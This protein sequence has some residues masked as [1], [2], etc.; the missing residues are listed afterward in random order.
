MYPK[1]FFYQ[2]KSSQAVFSSNPPGEIDIPLFIKGK[3]C[4]KRGQP[5]CEPRKKTLI[6]ADWTAIAWP[7][8]KQIEFRNGLLKLLDDDFSLY[9]WQDGEVV[10][11]TARFIARVDFDTNGNIHPFFAKKVTPA[12]ADKILSIASKQLHFPKDQLH[13]L[14]DYWM[15]TLIDFNLQGQAR[16]IDTGLYYQR[17]TDRLYDNNYADDRND[18]IEVLYQAVPPV[19]VIVSSILPDPTGLGETFTEAFPEAKVEE[20]YKVLIL[21][22]RHLLDDIFEIQTSSNPV[23]DIAFDFTAV[24]SIS[25]INGDI[26]Y[27]DLALIARTFDNL[28]HVSLSLD[29]YHCNEFP[30]DFSALIQLEALSIYGRDIVNGTL[31]A[32][33]SATLELKSLEITFSITQSPL[34]FEIFPLLKLEHLSIQNGFFLTPG[35][36][37]SLLINSPLLKTFRITNCEYL[38]FQ[39]D[40]VLEQLQILQVKLCALNMSNFFDFLKDKS[41]LTALEINNCNLSQNNSLGLISPVLSRLETINIQF[42]DMHGDALD[43]LIGSSPALKNLV[44]AN[45]EMPFSSNCHF[46]SRKLETLAITDC[47]AINI[48]C[49]MALPFIVNLKKLDLTD[50]TLIFDVYPQRVLPL[51]VLKLGAAN[52]SNEQLKQ[53]LRLLP[54]LKQLDLNQCYSLDIECDS[55]LRELLGKIAQVDWSDD[56]HSFDESASDLSDSEDEQVECLHDPRNFIDN[57]P[58]PDE[59]SFKFQGKNKTFNQRMIIE[60]L[61]QYLKIKNKHLALIP[62]LQG[63]ICNALSMRF[64]QLSLEKW[65]AFIKEIDFWDG[66]RY[67]LTVTMEAIFEDLLYTVQ[68]FQLK[69][70]EPEYFLG[71]SA[72]DFLKYHRATLGSG[73]VLSNPWHA[74]AVKYISESDEW[75][76]YDPNFLEGFEFFSEDVLMT[77]LHRSLGALILVC[78]WK[79]QLPALKPL[80]ASHF[81]SEGGLLALTK[82]QNHAEILVSFPEMNAL[83]NYKWNNEAFDG[84]FLRTSRG[85]PAWVLGLH[86]SQIQAYTLSVL[87]QCILENP[88][89][90]FQRIAHSME[91]LTPV[92]KQKILSGL[93][94]ETKPDALIVNTVTQAISQA[95]NKIYYLN[96]LA[97]WHKHKA[98]PETLPAYCQ[99]LIS[100]GNRN[101]K[102]LIELNGPTSV[103]ALQLALQSHCIHNA[104]PVFY[105]DHP[106]DLVC[107]A[108]Y[109]KLIKHH[110]GQLKK[111]PGGHLHDFL[112]MAKGKTDPAPVLIINYA[113]FKADDIVRMNSLLDD[114][115]SA[116]GTPIPEA[117]QLI[118]LYDHEAVD[119]Y[120]GEDFYSRFDL[121]ERCPL[122]Q[123]ALDVSISPLPLREFNAEMNDNEFP[124]LISLYHDSNWKVRLLGHWTLKNNQLVFEEGVLVK[125]LK[126][127]KPGQDILIENGL[128]D[129]LSFQQFWH[130]AFLKGYIECEG[131]TIHWPHDQQLVCKEGYQWP[132]L[133]G[134]LIFYLGLKPDVEVLNPYTL[135]AYFSRY[136]CDNEQETLNSLPGWIET[137][138][139][140]TLHVNLT[141]DLSQDEWAMLLD[142][143]RHWQVRLDCHVYPGY[144]APGFLQANWSDAAEEIIQEDAAAPAAVLLISSDPDITQRKLIQLNKVWKII[145]ISECS[146]SD[147]LGGIEGEVDSDNARFSFRQTASSLQTLLQAEE[148][149]ILKGHFST[150]LMDALAPLLLARLAYPERCM[151]QLYLVTQD[152]EAFAYLGCNEDTMSLDDKAGCLINDGFSEAEI[153]ALDV[154]FFEREPLSRCKA[155]L[156]HLRRH[157]DEPIEKSWQ[158]LM[159]PLDS[160]PPLQAINLEQSPQIT[161]AFTKRRLQ[162]LNQALLDGPYVFLSGLTGVGKS[163]F[164]EKEM[165]AQSNV[166]LFSGEEKIKAWAE[167][168]RDHRKILFIDEANLSPRQWSEFEGLFNQQPSIFLDGTY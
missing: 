8:W 111:G 160:L 42:T 1:I 14:D 165:A 79:E 31:V 167:D 33:L 130:H 92:Q 68:E 102:Q 117:L 157:P 52:I 37:R 159:Y 46:F 82:A 105:I 146:A 27:N 116:D 162:A 156:Q 90:A 3:P 23:Y 150:E 166:R 19:E 147:L 118:G 87:G 152:E 89:D 47:K 143:C 131:Q 138:A 34:Y 71:D 13:V 76:I 20:K 122:P 72:L 149:V 140:G 59:Q 25:L 28:K 98:G 109:V 26:K 155:A 10:P 38:Y 62:T 100:E 21:E 91:V 63:G 40:I 164:V 83:D 35:D 43:I 81:L 16:S 53:W 168:G 45:E 78:D 6:F 154:S 133:S 60:K 22:D 132:Q 145:D 11:F 107:S 65:R 12:S 70:E 56:A 48:S 110:Q 141:R 129:T 99:K 74:I 29:H 84:L 125:A 126:F 58:S 86:H 108:A 119:C 120:Q 94:Q 66:R 113:Q 4:W 80:E 17:F 148:A 153:W 44:I 2:Q 39:N 128:W 93:I 158:G 36:I 95:S 97:T 144:Q 137:H 106:D 18:L 49:L 7:V 30:D 55:E 121:V 61:C 103:M 112:E 136:H 64:I 85:I 67:S 15:G 75:C 96:Q 135:T 114:H 24:E 161:E 73:C 127:R 69:Q 54:F 5:F 101:R 163:T 32:L 124:L 142:T 104:R 9:C 51:E 134:Q 123:K 151:G 57:L 41:E 88:T 139:G 50:S 77:V 115:R